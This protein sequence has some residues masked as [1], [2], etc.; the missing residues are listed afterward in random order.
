MA[1]PFLYHFGVYPPGKEETC[2]IMPKVVEADIRQPVF[3]DDLFKVPYKVS[4]GKGSI[5]FSDKNEPLF[6]ILS[7]AMPLSMVRA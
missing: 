6:I 2:M 7:F 1:K 3:L 4:W 5:V